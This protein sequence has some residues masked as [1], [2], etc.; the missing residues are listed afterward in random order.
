[1][2]KILVT[3]QL[4]D[5]FVEQLEQFGDVKVWEKAIVPM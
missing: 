4:P 1:M 2:V 5:R 3:R